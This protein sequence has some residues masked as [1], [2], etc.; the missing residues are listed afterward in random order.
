MKKLER[1]EELLEEPFLPQKLD[2]VEL[3]KLPKSFR[4]EIEK[5]G[6]VWV[7]LRN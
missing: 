4:E 6:K 1:I 7:D 3:R 5:E 2:I